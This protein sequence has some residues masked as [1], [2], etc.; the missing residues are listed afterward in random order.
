MLEERPDDVAPIVDV[1]P[2]GNNSLDGTQ[3][4]A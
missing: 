1:D 4:L 3:G 2:L